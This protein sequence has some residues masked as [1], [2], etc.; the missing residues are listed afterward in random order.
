LSVVTEVNDSIIELLEFITNKSKASLRLLSACFVLIEITL[1]EFSGIDFQVLFELLDHIGGLIFLSL[2]E[3]S[4]LF[5]DIFSKFTKIC[6]FIRYFLNLLDLRV[7]ADTMLL[8]HLK[9][10]LKAVYFQDDVISLCE[11]ALNIVLYRN[12]SFHILN[13]L[14]LGLSSLG[15]LNNKGVKLLKA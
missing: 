4:N 2:N 5:A 9:G 3:R 12:E 15:S 10:F 14:I 13:I 1:L 11:Y 8:E 7:F 6:E